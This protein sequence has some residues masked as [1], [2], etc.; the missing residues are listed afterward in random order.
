MCLVI[1]QELLHSN[2][3]ASLI[4]CTQ[5]SFLNRQSIPVWLKFSGK[6]KLLRKLSDQKCRDW[7]SLL[8]PLYN[9]V[10]WA[11]HLHIKCSSTEG[12]TLAQKWEHECR[13]SSKWGWLWDQCCLQHQLWTSLLVRARS[14]L[15]SA[16]IRFSSL[17]L[18]LRMLSLRMLIRRN[19]S[20]ANLIEK[21]RFN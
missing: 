8:V 12:A 21:E 16:R 18:S 15:S 7:E 10:M 17:T 3:A 1:K 6:M 14:H 19:W 2:H 5:G 9:F 11:F 13:I 20:S 4:A